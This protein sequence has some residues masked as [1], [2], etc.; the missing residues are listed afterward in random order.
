[1]FS[2]GVLRSWAGKLTAW[3]WWQHGLQ[4]THVAALLSGSW[5]PAGVWS[6]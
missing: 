6:S 3:R 1:V 5:C 2:A 4:G